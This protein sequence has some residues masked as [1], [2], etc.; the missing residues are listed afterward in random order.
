M[1]PA[2]V[3]SFRQNHEAGSSQPTSSFS[4]RFS[5]LFFSMTE[6]S[7]R[8]STVNLRFRFWLPG[9]PFASIAEDTAVGRL[10]G[11]FMV[12]S[13]FVDGPTN[14]LAV[15]VPAPLLLLGAILSCPRPVRAPS[16]SCAS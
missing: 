12:A 4:F 15:T 14:V 9:T 6:C 16:L 1:R 13:L 10:L 5:L 11:F 8:S 7:R 2:T 3:V